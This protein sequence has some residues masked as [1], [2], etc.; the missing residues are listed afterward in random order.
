MRRVCKEAHF[1]V[2]QVHRV[3]LICAPPGP[4]RT[5]WTTAYSRRTMQ[6]TDEATPSGSITAGP[7]NGLVLQ[8]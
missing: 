3:R 8:P 4:S 5:P 7:R 2:T 6:P 1:C